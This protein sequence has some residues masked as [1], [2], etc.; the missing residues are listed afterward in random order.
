MFINLKNTTTVILNKLFNSNVVYEID[1]FNHLETMHTYNNNETFPLI[2][3]RK[4]I[5]G[6]YNVV[7]NK[8]ADLIKKSRKSFH[9]GDRINFNNYYV[10][11][12]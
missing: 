11:F 8:M 6:I 4:L 7:R 5:T 1:Q 10:L 12:L 9:N 3:L 2:I